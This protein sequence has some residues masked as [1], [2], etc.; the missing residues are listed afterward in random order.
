[1]TTMP[2]VCIT[3]SLSSIE[4]KLTLVSYVDRLVIGSATKK[5]FLDY[6]SQ[7]RQY[8]PQV[9][10]LIP[11]PSLYLLGDSPHRCKLRDP[12]S[13]WGSGTKTTRRRSS[14]TSPTSTT[15]PRTWLASWR[16]TS[17][18]NRPYSRLQLAFLTCQPRHQF[19]VPS[20]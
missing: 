5:Q 19:G 14:C 9:F 15:D 8:H 17:L 6:F 7:Y 16:A 4:S 20:T 3:R 12:S 18:K 2:Q 10:I 11:S 13:S 1:M